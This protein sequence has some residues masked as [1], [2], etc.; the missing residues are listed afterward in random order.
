MKTDE[1]APPRRPRSRRRSNRRPAIWSPVLSCP[2]DGGTDRC[3]RRL[4]RA[5]RRTNRFE[6]T[7]RSG[8][9]DL[10]DPTT[11]PRW[12]RPR[13]ARAGRGPNRSARRR[14]FQAHSCL[15]QPVGGAREGGGA[16]QARLDVR[17]WSFALFSKGS[18]GTSAWAPAATVDVTP[19]EIRKLQNKPRPTKGPT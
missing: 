8:G 1:K 14:N 19:P 9:N 11:A 13:R 2:R 12:Q 15:G 17:T 10:S 6:F 7:M 16:G 3:K 18:Q 4:A 5:S